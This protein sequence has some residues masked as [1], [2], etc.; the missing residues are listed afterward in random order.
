M[1]AFWAETGQDRITIEAAV[2]YTWTAENACET[3]TGL[4]RVQ[5]ED[6]ECNI[7]IPNAFTPDENGI[8]EVFI[9]S[10]N[11]E[12]A[13]YQLE[14]YNRWG[15]VIFKSENPNEAWD[16]DSGSGFYSQNEVYTYLLTYQRFFDVEAKTLKGSLTILR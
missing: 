4:T 1:L 13:A 10:I 6:C 15:E 11:C 7:Y 3:L 2:E 12:L 16:G 8:N 9:P 14:I 5:F